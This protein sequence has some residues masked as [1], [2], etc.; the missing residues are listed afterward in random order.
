MRALR[1]PLLLT[2]YALLVLVVTATPA[3]GLP[4]G[5][6]EGHAEPSPQPRSQ[7]SLQQ[8]S[9]SLA[10]VKK[11]EPSL[12]RR[13]L[14]GDPLGQYPVIIELVEQA[15]LSSLPSNLVR[16]DRGHAVVSE[17]QATAEKTQAGLVGFLHSQQARGKA[18]QVHVFWVFN[19]LAVT[20]DAETL[21]AVAAR[22]EVRFIREDRQRQ[23]L[24]PFEAEITQSEAE[25]GTLEWNVERI[26]ADLAWDNL[27]LDGTGVTVAIMDTGVDWQHPA[28]QS[29]Y[30]GFKP[31]GPSAHEGNWFCATSEGYIYP[32]DGHGH[33]TH[34][35]GTALGRQDADGVAIGVAPGAQW[36]AVKALDDRGYAY[37]SWIHAAFEWLLAPEGDPALAPDVVNGSWGYRDDQYEAFRPDLQALRAAGI[38]PV[39]AAGNEGP[40]PS[41]LRSPPSYPEAIAVGATD[42][43]DLVAYF[44]SRGPSPWGETKPEI[45]APG[46][47]IR[48]SLLG[49]TYG[50][51][52]GTSMASPHATG[53]VALML[54]A[55]PALS[56]DDVEAIMAS[57]ALPLGYQIP[58]NDTGWGRIDAYRASAVALRAGYVVGQVTRQSDLQP[59]PTAQIIAYDLLGDA[60][61]RV[62]V[63]KD[64]RYNL[65]I[66]EGLYDIEASAFGFNPSTTSAVLVQAST[67]I[68]L[69]MS[70]SP[71]PAGVLWGEIRDAETGGPVSAQILIEG[72]PAWTTSDPQTGQYSM[73]LP[74]G[75]YTV[76]ASL[77][78]YRRSTAGN[79]E[80]LVD[81]ATRQDFSLIPAPTLL[82]VDAGR[83]YD[84]SQIRYFESALD[85]RD[86]VYDQWEIR[87]VDT[88]IPQEA[89]LAPFDVTIW[90]A[91]IGSPALIGAGDVISNYLSTGGNLFITGQ[92]VGYWD[93]GLSGFIYHPY[94]RRL[95]KAEALSDSA[96]QASVLGLPGDILDGLTLP[97]NGPDSARNQ[98]L[99]DLIDVADPLN[100]SMIGTYE[101]GGGA[102][103]RAT[104]CQTY[105][106]V[107]L[108]AGFEGLGDRATRA[109][110]MDRALT[111]LDLPQPSVQARLVPSQQESVWLGTVPVSYTV[112]LKN[113]GGNT[114]QFDLE[115]SPA[116]WSSSIWDGNF[117]REI[118][119]SLSLVPCQT[120][121]VGIQ[122]T[123]P[124][125]TGWD[126]TEVVTLT[127][128][129]QADP[130]VAAL[131]AF[132][133]KTPAPILLVDDHRNF[134]TSERYQEALEAR[135]LPYDPWRIALDA[136]ADAT[137]PSLERLERYPVVIWFTAYDWYKTLTPEEESKL[138]AYLDGGGR[139]LLS[140]QD[141][142]RT[143]GFTSFARDYLGIAKYTEG[144]VVTQ[145]VSAV[146]HPVGNGLATMDLDYPFRNLSDALRAN[147]EADMAF[148]G[149]HGQ[150]VALT[151]ENA[152][153]KTAFYAFSLEA[154][155]QDDMPEV[156]GNTVDWLSPLGD[157]TLV[158]GPPVAVPGSELTCTLSVRNTS[159]RL[160][161]QASLSNP[162]PPSTSLVQ[163]S[164]E[165]PA[166]YEP[167]T[168]S[169]AWTGALAP[170][171]AITVTYLLQID[172][173]L[174]DGT[175][176]ENVAR[177]SDETGLSLERVATSRVDS[178]HLGGS[179]KAVSTDI[180]PAGQTLTYTLYLQNDGLQPAEARLTDPIP[181][182]SSHLPGTGWASSGLL[183][184]TEQ[185][186]VW[187]GTIGAGQGVTVT[188]PVTIAS[189]INGFYVHNRASLTDGWGDVVP[190]ETYTLVEARLSLPLILK[191]F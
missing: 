106:A 37:D 93:D 91:P 131:A 72:T 73:A 125:E 173:P 128:R 49:G 13:L 149:Q 36:I 31:G 85:D 111:W 58:N 156:L 142:L 177:L 52:N 68:T 65:A 174:A 164:L 134:D 63:D 186:L 101:H 157:S 51:A 163:G 84:D 20:T 33:G 2:A 145:T 41:S 60:L 54:Q 35:T 116:A 135:H 132:S 83:W 30:R 166:T 129:S 122:V 119:Q 55:D 74:A 39:F 6:A 62:P 161:S 150:P 189:I 175:I 107:Y 11:T 46:V 103:L 118:T 96:G 50:I 190:L 115:L 184:S 22:P 16:Q 47:Q 165:G 147:T 180:S 3:R 179:V 9:I 5:Q 187:S 100:A 7:E 99:P 4:P 146:G 70:L 59:L 34:V 24:D 92:D 44:S 28:L 14:E 45:S 53:L 126:V 152:P 8:A 25:D 110:V 154:L 19:G 151:M 168:Q 185:V 40:Y 170:D 136:A 67:S 32:T 140:S 76:T 23:W 12:L 89:D 169:I 178:P 121:T 42:D 86:Y 133:T 77:N 124:P 160:L 127:A 167:G 69:D 1:L 82:L 112:E 158:V 75:A 61:A 48:S 148:W 108:A 144:L 176:I 153:W 57:T 138:S 80:I 139:F 26:R 155:D 104:G 64:G 90:S 94:Y 18:K 88:D 56:I 141:Y 130:S 27:G 172:R 191:G 29:Q 38:V 43:Q 66:P 95:L 113:L 78:G 123:V 87:Y 182:N 181:V 97:M 71:A 81:E 143:S 102:A 114:D 17:L 120:Q 188:F 10:L 15:D 109:E 105:R 183:S 98:I 137:S 171:E 21:G 162:I 79:V 117:T 159:P